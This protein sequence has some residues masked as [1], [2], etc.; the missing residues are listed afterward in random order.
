MY[1]YTI[2]ING[3]KCQHCE[4][5]MDEALKAKYN[6][7]KVKS[8]HEENQTILITEDEVNENELKDIVTETGYRFVSMTKEPYKKKFLFF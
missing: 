3:M 5:H 8:S 6:V 2:K 1:K 4:A 7:K